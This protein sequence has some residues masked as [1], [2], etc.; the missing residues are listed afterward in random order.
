MCQLWILKGCCWHNRLAFWNRH[1]TVRGPC[2]WLQRNT[3]ASIEMAPCYLF[4]CM[5]CC[6]EKGILKDGLCL[7]GL[8]LKWCQAIPDRWALIPKMLWP[9]KNVCRWQFS[10]RKKEFWRASLVYLLRKQ[11][12]LLYAPRNSGKSGYA[13]GHVSSPF[14]VLHRFPIS[15][16]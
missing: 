9:E 4:K 7:E 10:S 15:V 2:C 1:I 3:F 13:F 14:R 5:S 8:Y 11:V 6:M 12:S 16:A